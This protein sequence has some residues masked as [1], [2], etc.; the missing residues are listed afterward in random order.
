MKIQV[1]GENHEAR[2]GATLL[3]VV[4]KLHVK[5]KQKVAVLLND[6]VIPADKQAACILKAGDRVEILT[7]AGGG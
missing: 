4:K 1:N 3:D 7:F 5:K 2:Q 6:E